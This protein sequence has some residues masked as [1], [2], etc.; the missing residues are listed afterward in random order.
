M[1]AKSYLLLLLNA[2]LELS[3]KQNS[4]FDWFDGF[5]NL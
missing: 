2:N 4:L 3:R 1:G 5:Y